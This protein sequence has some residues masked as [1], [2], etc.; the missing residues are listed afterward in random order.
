MANPNPVIQ[1]KTQFQPGNTVG[2]QFEDGNQAALKH[3]VRRAI[4]DLAA[5]RPLRGDLAV[6][7]HRYDEQLKTHDGRIAAQRWLASGFFAVTQGLLAVFQSAVEGDER[8]K[9]VSYAKHFATLGTKAGNENQR[10]DD[11][12]HARDDHAIDYDEL[13]KRM[14]AK[15]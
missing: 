4:A 1:T 13:V 9:A 10:L 14:E 2:E 5:G 7:Q 12:E 3:G 8:E 15:P 11:M 6:I